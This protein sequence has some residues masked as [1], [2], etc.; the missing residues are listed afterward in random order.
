MLHRP[1]EITLQ[2]CRSGDLSLRYNNKL[3]FL[4]SDTF[5]HQWTAGE[6]TLIP[7]SYGQCPFHCD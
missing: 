2:I 6:V 1:V 3:Q 5:P 7:K 4:I